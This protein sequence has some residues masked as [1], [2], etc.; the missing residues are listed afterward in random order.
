MSP[1]APFFPDCRLLR[2]LFFHPD[3]L[4]SPTLTTKLLSG[5]W[6]DRGSGSQSRLIPILTKWLSP[7]LLPLPKPE[8]KREGF[9]LPSRV[10]QTT[11]FPTREWDAKR[12]EIVMRWMVLELTTAHGKNTKENAQGDAKIKTANSGGRTCVHLITECH[13]PYYQPPNPHRPF[14]LQSFAQHS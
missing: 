5:S 7:F 10:W 12:K 6:R 4:P 11:G 1:L 9:V 3:P 8:G 13:K 14:F 2:P